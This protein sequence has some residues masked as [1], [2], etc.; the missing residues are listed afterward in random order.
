MRELREEE[1]RAIAAGYASGRPSGMSNGYR[2]T[3]KPPNPLTVT[4]GTPV[5]PGLEVPG[6]LPAWRF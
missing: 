2:G 6:A 1:M 5:E 3:W 4:F